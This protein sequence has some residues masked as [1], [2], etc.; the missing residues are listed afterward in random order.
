MSPATGSSA[1]ARRHGSQAGR[2][3]SP[4]PRGCQRTARPALPGLVLAAVLALPAAAPAAGDDG[5][6][7]AARLLEARL[8]G[9]RGLVAHFTQTLDAASLPA[10]QREEG[11]LYL[12]RPGRMRWEFS[13]PAGKLAIA[14]GQR[15]WMYVPDDRQIFVAPLRTA[16]G[17]RGL[18]FLLDAHVDLASEFR[19]S[20]GPP[21]A[22][23]AARSLELRPRDKASAYDNL[24]IEVSS[25]G[26]PSTVVL[27]DP[28]GERVTYRFT[29]VRPK[30]DLDA[31][32]FRYAPPP[33]VPVQ[34]AGR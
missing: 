27:V 1:G 2:E 8:D 31:A 6:L 9:I 28:L 26:F 15:S 7:A 12:L 34:E 25:D 11:T 21:L 4:A 32:L 13:T 23:K 14:D 16:G 20:W 19:I 5:A 30:E 18:E 24:L 33:G 10:P 17:H 3:F 29:D 22:P